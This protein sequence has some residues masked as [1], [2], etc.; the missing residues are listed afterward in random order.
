MTGC[1]VVSAR[2]LNVLVEG[3]NQYNTLIYQH[4]TI[5]QFN[6][7]FHVLILCCHSQRTNNAG[8]DDVQMAE[9]LT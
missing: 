5:L 9:I 3:V 8:S 7:L 2:V 4:C 1:I 6:G